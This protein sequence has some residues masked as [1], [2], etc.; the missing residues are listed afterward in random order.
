MSNSRE[1][2]A[3]FWRT[4]LWDRADAWLPNVCEWVAAI[5]LLGAALLILRLV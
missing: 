4:V 2:N 5:A 1:R 3:R